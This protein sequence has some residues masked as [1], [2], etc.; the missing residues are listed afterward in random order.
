MKLVFQNRP[1]KDKN[2]D[3]SFIRLQKITN[4]T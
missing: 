1:I 2:D 3:A 4:N